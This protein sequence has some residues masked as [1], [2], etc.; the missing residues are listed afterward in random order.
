MT[1]R[2]ED[3]APPRRRRIW[4]FVVLAALVALGV[5]GWSALD[6]HAD[7]LSRAQAM[8]A[9]QLLGEAKV[10]LAEYMAERKV[11]PVRIEEVVSTTSNR[12]TRS[13]VITKGAGSPGPLEISATLNDTLANPP[14]RG[15]TVLMST[16]DGGNTWT[17]R[18]GSIDAKYLPAS[19]RPR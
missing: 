11:W 5:A 2:T 17:C 4:P 10:P 16:V 15:K 6:L 1:D 12:F 14:I 8:D 13:I 3:P 9:V 7:N 18:P 19:C